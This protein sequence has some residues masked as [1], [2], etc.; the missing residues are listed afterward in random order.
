M[1]EIAVGVPMFMREKALRRLLQSVPSYVEAVYVADNGADDD[2]DVYQAQYPFDL[3]V[4]EL[5]YDAG[6]GACRHALVEASTEEYLWMGDNDMEFTD[7]NDLQKLASILHEH[8]DLGGVSG[9][10]IEGDT[11][12]AGARD[13]QLHDGVAI[14]EAAGRPELET[15]PYP[16]ARFDFIPQAGLFRRECYETYSYDASVESTEHLDFFVGHRDAGEWAFASTPTVMIQHNR[17]IN[18]EYRDSERGGDHADFDIMREKWGI[19][20]TVPGARTDW[21]YVRGG[22]KSQAFD[23]V[24][25]TTPAPVWTR[26]RA[27]AE[28]A[29]IA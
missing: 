29:G 12:R 22:V 1:S 18:Q 19:E 23:V 7:P 27:A 20:D 16:F 2:R 28:R 24:K 6:I 14:K 21:G 25:R 4:V 11:V 17:N 9:W 13:L 26:I 3:E 5:P 10:L 8:P 15:D